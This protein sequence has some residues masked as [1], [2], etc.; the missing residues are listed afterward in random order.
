[1]C[2]T[3]KPPIITLRRQFVPLVPGSTAKDNVEEVHALM[4]I[5]EYCCQE[6]GERFEKLVRGN[7]DQNELTCPNCGSKQA[8][9]LLSV[10]GTSGFTTT[11]N[12]T[13]SSS[14]SCEP[15]GQPT[16]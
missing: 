14:G 12:F 16:G 2:W 9:K 7:S 11:P 8:E 4:P 13:S 6:C 10:F 15:A 1:M 5:Y 3:R